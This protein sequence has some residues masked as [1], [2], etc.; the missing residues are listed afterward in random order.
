MDG[1]KS[2]E[3]DRVLHQGEWIEGIFSPDED[4]YHFD[5]EWYP[6]NSTSEHNKIESQHQ[7]TQDKIKRQ[8][9]RMKQQQSNNKALANVVVIVL[10]IAILIWPR[11]I[12]GITIIDQASVGCPTSAENSL[13]WDYDSECEN[14]RNEGLT[15]AGI[16]LGVGVLVLVMINRRPSKQKEQNT[17]RNRLREPF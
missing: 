17:L 16:I 8:N 15:H 13:L 12:F 2:P 11:G 1:V 4:S 10:V 5:G 14:W 7:V 3:G 6:L 9:K